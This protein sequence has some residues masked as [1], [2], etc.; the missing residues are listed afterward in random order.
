MLQIMQLVQLLLQLVNKLYK[1]IAFASRNLSDTKKR[2]S[3]SEREFLSIVYAY[4]H[5]I[6][7]FLVEKSKFS[8][9]MN[10]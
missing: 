2:Y 1:P 7:M 3:A 5:F 10:L 9:I 6:L 4:D 8:Q